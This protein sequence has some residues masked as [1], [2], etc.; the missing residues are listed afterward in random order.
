MKSCFELNTSL[1]KISLALGGVKQ[2]PY[3]DF[4]EWLSS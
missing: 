4:V 1:T 3:F 2:C